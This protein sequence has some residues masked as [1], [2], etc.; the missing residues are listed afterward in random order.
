MKSK[1][2]NV[3][4]LG[5]ASVGKTSIIQRIKDGTFNENV[6]MTVYLDNFIIK[7]KYEKKI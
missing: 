6:K 4:T 7:R 3:I 1:T 2:I 5:D